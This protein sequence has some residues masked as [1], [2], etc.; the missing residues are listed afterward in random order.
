[1]A[2][3]VTFY[4][5]FFNDCYILLISFPNIIGIK[6]KFL[7]VLASI[8]YC[9]CYNFVKYPTFRW[10][11]ITFSFMLTI[12]LQIQQFCSHIVRESLRGKQYLESP[13]ARAD[14]D[15]FVF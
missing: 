12:L 6:P 1:M 4:S 11:P 9:K 8:K 15:R 3:F 7:V 13:L 10:F 14:S 5:P 2:N